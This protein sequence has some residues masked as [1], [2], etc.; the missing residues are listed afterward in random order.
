M[1]NEKK[2]TPEMANRIIA[3]LM[4][5]TGTDFHDHPPVMQLGRSAKPKPAL[6]LPAIT[7][8][9]ESD[10]RRQPHKRNQTPIEVREFVLT[11]RHM[12]MPALLNAIRSNYGISRSDGWVYR[13]WQD[14]RLVAAAAKH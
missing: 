13:Q 12:E 9:M 8:R 1:S 10:K 14:A 4:S 6:P 5:Q 3:L 7:T 2:C 11:N